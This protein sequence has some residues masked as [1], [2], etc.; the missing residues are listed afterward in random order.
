MNRLHSSLRIVVAD[1]ERDVGQFFEKLLNQLGHEVVAVAATGRQLVEMCRATRP[2]LVLTD[3]QMP[4]MDG[5]EAAALLNRERPVP[6]ILVSGDPDDSLLTRAGADH[7]MGYLAKP[8]KLA[9]LQ[10]A[11]TLA[12][13][14]FE[15]VQRMARETADLRQA[16]EDRKIIERAKGAIMRRLRVD[17]GEAYRRLRKRASDQNRKLIEVAQEVLSAEQAFY[18]LERH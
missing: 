4:D 18:E 16:L 15:H 3:V 17:E 9:D 13:R 5:I 2:D 11:I 7:V 1:D 14:H 8:V 10:I 12:L 6:V